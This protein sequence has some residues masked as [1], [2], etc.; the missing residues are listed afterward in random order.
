MPTCAPGD[1]PGRWCR[2]E[3][4]LFRAGA[5]RGS[6][7]L[8]T[9]PARP[10]DAA[11]CRPVPFPCPQ[12]PATMAAQLSVEALVDMFSSL[13]AAT[14]RVRR[15]WR[16]VCF[17]AQ[18]PTSSHR[19]ASGPSTARTFELFPLPHGRRTSWSSAATTARSQ[20]STCWP[21][22]TR[23]RG[24]NGWRLHLLRRGRGRCGEGLGPGRWWNLP[25]W[26][27]HWRCHVWMI[28]LRFASHDYVVP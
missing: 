26:R 1:L 3:I 23:R 14:V 19:R 20:W 5:A 10:R 16:V 22:P 17:W 9:P 24:L 27:C 25:S 18:P 15:V 2:A 8:H 13:S 12:K 7:E 6:V 21:W 28:T 11:A 4:T